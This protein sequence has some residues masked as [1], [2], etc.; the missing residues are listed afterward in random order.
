MAFSSNLREVTSQHKEKRHVSDHLGP[1]L[2][3]I[4]SILFIYYYCFGGVIFE[5]HSLKDPLKIQINIL[6]ATQ[7]RWI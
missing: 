2:T 5:K 1:K 6:T 3:I 4:K 7:R